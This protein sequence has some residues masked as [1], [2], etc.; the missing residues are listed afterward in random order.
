MTDTLQQE[1]NQPFLAIQRVYLRGQSLELPQGA[2]I[3]VTPA[4]PAMNLA[5]QVENKNLAENIY[6]VAIRSTLTAQSGDKTLYLLEVEQAGIFELRNLTQE[7]L[8]DVLEIQA[9][10]MLAPYLR[11]QISDAL[12]RATLPLF[13]LPE[14]NWPGIAAEQRAGASNK[15]PVH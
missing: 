7:Q 4:E 14:I 3:F 13:Y 11:S 6:E 8:R 2:S 10:A 9:P 1:N 5:L 15:G 12:T